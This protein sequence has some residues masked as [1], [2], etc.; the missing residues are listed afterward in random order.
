MHAPAEGGGGSSSHY[1]VT[2][3]PACLLAGLPPPPRPPRQTRLRTQLRCPP[4][5]Q[6]GAG[7]PQQ[8]LHPQRCSP[9]I[10][11]QQAGMIGLLGC[12]L[13][14]CCARVGPPESWQVQGP[15]N[16]NCNCTPR[17]QKQAV[18]RSPWLPAAVVNETLASPSPTPTAD[19]PLTTPDTAGVTG[20]PWAGWCGSQPAAPRAPPVA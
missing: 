11:R 12:R 3:L 7:I 14:A 20:E 19:T 4:P 17:P 6:V 18:R 1:P 8:R 15:C 2:C 9:R 5:P 10:P 13:T 16:C